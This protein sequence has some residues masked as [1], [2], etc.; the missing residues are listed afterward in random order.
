[1]QALSFDR[2]LIE[3]PLTAQIDGWLSGTQTEEAAVEVASIA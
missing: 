3:V 1:M 2:K